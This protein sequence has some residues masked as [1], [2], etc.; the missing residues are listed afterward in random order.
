MCA[1]GPARPERRPRTGVTDRGRARADDRVPRWSPEPV[2]DL[3]ERGRANYRTM[4]EQR[5]RAEVP[6]VRQDD[7]PPTMGLLEEFPVTPPD[8]SLL[9][10]VKDIELSGAQVCHP[11]GTATT[12]NRSISRSVASTLQALEV[13]RIRRPSTRTTAGNRPGA[14]DR[15]DARHHRQRHTVSESIHRRAP[16]DASRPRA[17]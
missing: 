16:L 5:Q 14:I 12:Y 7:S 13:A 9:F 6:I 15:R 2:C 4:P 17:T 8:P 11:F 3:A 1:R 10:D